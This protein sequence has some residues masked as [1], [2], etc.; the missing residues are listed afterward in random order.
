MN[1]PSEEQQNIIDNI[2]KGFNVMVQA[3]AGSGKSTTVLSLAKQNIHLEILQ[4]TYNSSLRLD[5]KEAIHK[6]KLTNLQAHTYHSLAVKYYSK[7]AHT[8]TGIRNILYYNKNPSLFI[9]K[10]DIL[11]IDENQDISE[12]YFRFVL[13]FLLDHNEYIQILFLG[14]VRQCIYQFK[15][16]D[17]RYLS[18]ASKIWRNFIFLQSKEFISC[19]LKTSYRITDQM[20]SFIN[21]CLIG[22]NI[23]NTCRN[24]EPIKYLRNNRP[25]IEKMIIFNVKKL[26]LNGVKP[27]EIFIL[28]ASIKSLNVRK[29][30]NKLV[31]ENIPCYVPIFDSEKL[32]ERVID[33]KIVFSTFHSVK[34]RQR[35]FVFVIGFDNG[36]FQY[37]RNIE[38]DICPNT[39]YVGSSRAKQQLF[40][41]EYDHFPNDKPFDFLKMSHHD[42][43]SSNFIDFKGIPGT[44][45]NNN[46]EEFVSIS[47]KRYETASKIVQFIPEHVLNVITPILN[48]L[49]LA[50]SQPSFE[51]SIPNVVA[52]DYGFEDVSDL[53]GIAIPCLFYEKQTKNNILNN[54]LD[55]EIQEINNTD[56]SFLKN[57]FNEIPEKCETM[58]D[59]LFMSNVL[60]SVQQKLYFKLK[61]INRH[62]YN[63]IS[64]ETINMCI[65]RLENTININDSMEFEKKIIHHSFEDYHK[66]IDEIMRPYFGNVLIRFTCIV[67]I[68][69]NDSLWEIKCTNSLTIEHKIQLVLY[70]WICEVLDI[71]KKEYKLFNIK[72]GELLTL[73]MDFDKITYIIVELLKGK[74][75]KPILQN[76]KDFLRNNIV[77]MRTQCINDILSKTDHFLDS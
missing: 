58:N 66:K 71:P 48:D 28:A 10:F 19:S 37:A 53:N 6:N 44:I 9:K 74:Y 20:G 73:N 15:G 56:H 77:Y 25:N 49:F 24:G 18:F 5:I 29:I 36:Y 16:A 3:V 61:Q 26:L 8:D 72:T 2:V 42:M 35:N 38:K 47:D 31:E 13:K 65:K 33:G 32:D 23:M 17:S 54:L 14:D 57:I 1:K 7:D 69:S 43:I 60:I 12:L 76:D 59:Y 27:D 51:I 70:A 62:Q 64:F 55:S 41:V 22:E 63:W 30:E 67:D 50:S 46:D 21:N 68:I 34:G 4:L 52:T 45:F 40:L 39:I 75:E 11:V